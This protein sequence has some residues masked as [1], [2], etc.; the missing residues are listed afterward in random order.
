MDLKIA[1]DQHGWAAVM[2]QVSLLCDDRALKPEER[3][4][5][6]LWEA[7]G[8]ATFAARMSKVRG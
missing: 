5:A 8:E 7:R 2:L 3:A 1:L 6:D 4:E